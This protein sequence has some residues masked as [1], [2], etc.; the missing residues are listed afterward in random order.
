MH[1]PWWIAGG[2]AIDLF[3][4]RTTRHHDDIDVQI[5]RAD[6]LAVQATL[7]TW[8]LNAADPPGTLRPWKP[9]E[10]LPA[11][12]HDIWCRPVRPRPGRFN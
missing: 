6:Q 7:A 11:H 9:G 3:V 10:V 5:Q 12:V 2:W 4:G 1:V 8:D